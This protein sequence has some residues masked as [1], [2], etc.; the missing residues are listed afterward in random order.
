MLTAVELIKTQSTPTADE[1]E[2]P[3]KRRCLPL[4]EMIG[5]KGG[6]SRGIK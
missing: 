5:V 3:R 1:A 4:S 2:R 6:A